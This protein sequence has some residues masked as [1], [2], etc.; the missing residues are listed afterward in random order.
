MISNAKNKTPIQLNKLNQV[1]ARLNSNNKILQ[2]NETNNNS[3]NVNYIIKYQRTI[4]KD[5]LMMIELFCK[6]MMKVHLKK[7]MKIIVYT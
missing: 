6:I 7:V 4:V 5:I 2:L 1:I 3:T